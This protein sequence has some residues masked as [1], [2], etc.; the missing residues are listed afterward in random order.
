MDG[1]LSLVSYG[2][3]TIL[4]IVLIGGLIVLII[5]D[6]TQKKHTVL[7]NFPVIG[8]PRELTG[9]PVGI[10]TAIGGWD[11]VNELCDTVLQRGKD[12]APDFLTSTAGKG[13][14]ARRPRP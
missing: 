4:G 12:H 2:L 11:F 9:R 10:K 6:V 3:G 5:H 1:M 14:A 13:A 8:R 7:R